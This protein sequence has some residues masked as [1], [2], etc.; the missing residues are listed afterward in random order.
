MLFVSSTLA[1]TERLTYRKTSDSAIGKAN[2]CCFG[3]GSNSGA[4]IKNLESAQV[5]MDFSLRVQVSWQ[6][7]T[8]SKSRL[9]RGRWERLPDQ[10]LL[11]YVSGP[12][13]HSVLVLG[14]GAGFEPTAN[15]DMQIYRGC[16][17]WEENWVG[18]Y[19]LEGMEHF[20]NNRAFKSA[21]L[22]HKLATARSRWGVGRSLLLQ[23]GQAGVRR[24]QRREARM[25]RR[26][27]A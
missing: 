6:P 10:P 21:P 4:R 13:Q 27:A 22:A 17:T 9:G 1:Q 20:S 26:Y 16:W 19:C 15:A 8:S 3:L 7:R 12:V 23:L 11:P 18:G 5:K 25:W 24:K 2:S 14:A